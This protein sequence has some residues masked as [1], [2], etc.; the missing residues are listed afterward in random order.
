M[1]F[2]PYDVIE[3]IMTF[4]DYRDTLALLLSNTYFYDMS[5]YL[6]QRKAKIEYDYQIDRAFG[7]TN[8]QKYKWIR[9]NMMSTFGN[10]KHNDDYFWRKKYTHDFDMLVPCDYN[11]CVQYSFIHEYTSDFKLNCIRHRLHMPIVRDKVLVYGAKSWTK[12]THIPLPFNILEEMKLYD[13]NY[14]HMVERWLLNGRFYDV[15]LLL[16]E[17]TYNMADI[18]HIVNKLHSVNTTHI[19][20]NLHK[21]SVKHEKLKQT[22]LSLHISLM[23]AERR[24]AII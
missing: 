17:F 4:M 10:I 16:Y 5:D 15:V 24:H 13:Y 11:P 2:L 1:N 3:L 8:G 19:H 9:E 22:C 14:V 20:H 21:I 7:T 23:E 18:Q 6:W 12:R